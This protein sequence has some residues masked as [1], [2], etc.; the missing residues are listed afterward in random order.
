MGGPP[1]FF[2]GVPLFPPVPA[3]VLS[4]VDL[5]GSERLQ[6][7]LS[8]GERLRETQSINASLS[9]LGHVIMALSKKVWGG[10]GGV[11]GS[12]EESSGPPLNPHTPPVS[13][14]EPHIPYR[15]SKLTYLLQNS[16]GGSSKM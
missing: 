13:P 7:S 10:P 9:A 16:L 3:A 2:W 15:N 8:Q 5:A 1:L 11:L 12:G 4:L 6:K 14:Q